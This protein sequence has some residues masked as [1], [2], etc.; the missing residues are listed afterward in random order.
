[1]FGVP[2]GRRAV[3]RSSERVAEL[4]GC[5]RRPLAAMVVT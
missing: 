2:A 5:E 4:R 3:G 1:V